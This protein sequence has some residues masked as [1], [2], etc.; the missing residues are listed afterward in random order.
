MPVLAAASAAAAAGAGGT[1][2]QYN[3]TQLRLEE[4]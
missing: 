1:L 4:K 3:R 2:F